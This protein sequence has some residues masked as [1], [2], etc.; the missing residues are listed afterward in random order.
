[1][2]WM[3]FLLTCCLVVLIVSIS[4]AAV[5]TQTVTYDSAGTRLIGYLASDEALSGK[6]PGIIVFP[7]WWGLNDYPK[8]RAR[9]LAAMGYVA[10]AADMYGEGKVAADSTEAGKLAGQFRGNWETGGRDLMRQRAQAALATLAANN[11]V[12]PNR[13]A[14]IGYCF[15]GT[16][17]LELAFSGADIRGA[18]SF[19][20]GLNVPQEGDLQRLK[21][22][23]LILHGSADTSVKP[24]TIA[25]LQE[26]LD[27]AGADWQ[28]VTYSGAK[29]GF[30][31]P[32]N[33][34]A[35]QEAAARRS[36]QAM[37]DFLREV[38]R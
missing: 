28:L 3:T 31:N 23:L 32:G 20:G 12:D 14:A 6:R 33:A 34:A 13:I 22:K 37:V 11:R 17:A 27:K 7:E 4:S 5:V 16:V 19:H 9:Q 2:N 26:A 25:A 30:S 36:W 29:H 24:E 10:F 8:E 18:V 21:A 1:M 38:L 15:G 35:Y